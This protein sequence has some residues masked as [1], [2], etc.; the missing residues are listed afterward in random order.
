MRSIGLRRQGFAAL[1][2]GTCQRRDPPLQVR[3]SVAG[4]ER[5]VFTWTLLSW[6]IS[7]RQMRAI[8]ATLE[9]PLMHHN[10][11]RLRED[12]DCNGSFA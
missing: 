11:L 6:S 7:R 1:P 10:P 8:S 4:L 2:N 5:P 12:G 3:P 9:S